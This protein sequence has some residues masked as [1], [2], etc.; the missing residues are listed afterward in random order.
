VP[1]Y[2]PGIHYEP[3]VFELGQRLR[4]F[5]DYVAHTAGPAKGARVRES[6]ERLGRISAL[7]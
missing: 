7:R 3:R 4:R 6:M 2:D 1:Q 5:A